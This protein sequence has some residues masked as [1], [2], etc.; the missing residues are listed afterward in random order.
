MK[1]C[2][3]LSAILILLIV[4]STAVLSQVKK[5]EFFGLKPGMNRQEVAELLKH[6]KYG[7]NFFD[8]MVLCSDYHK[9]MVMLK[10]NDQIL[11]SISIKD[12]IAD[13]DKVFAE[14]LKE[15]QA[16]YGKPKR[17]V[18]E[19]NFALFFNGEKPV[20]IRTIKKSEGGIYLQLLCNEKDCEDL[21]KIEE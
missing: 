9:Y 13:P 2:I 21:K 20:A 15:M 16:V 14:K 17:V 10:F 4:I 19:K 12:D 6:K 5:S 8:N 3:K 1:Y 11:N 7:C 18:K